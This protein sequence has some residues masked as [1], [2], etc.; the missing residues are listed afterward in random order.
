MDTKSPINFGKLRDKS[1]NIRTTARAIRMP[2]GRKRVVRLPHWAWLKWDDCSDARRER[3]ISSNW[4][5]EF[6]Q[7]FDHLLAANLHSQ[8][9]LAFQVEY[10][11]KYYRSIPGEFWSGG[12]RGV[13][14]DNFD[15]VRLPSFPDPYWQEAPNKWIIENGLAGF[16]YRI[17]G[18]EF[19]GED[20]I[21]LDSIRD[22]HLKGYP[23]SFL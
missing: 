3:M 12:L 8:C 2:H 6:A 17:K 21:D 15:P 20:A 9:R 5:A 1:W 16:A 10:W 4:C 14:N 19:P 22:C 23:P 7:L 13:A 11:Q 18:L